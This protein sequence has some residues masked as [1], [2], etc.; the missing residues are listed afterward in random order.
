[1]KK[2]LTILKLT[3]ISIGKTCLTCQGRRSSMIRCIYTCIHK[4]ITTSLI[5][6]RV[7]WYNVKMKPRRSRCAQ[8]RKYIGLS[9]L[10]SILRSI[11]CD[12]NQIVFLNASGIQ[13]LTNLLKM[14]KVK[15]NKLIERESYK[16]E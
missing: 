5:A 11:G 3:Q 8:E 4:L 9:E 2:T 13:N 12:Y 1:M 7:Q 10:N 6:A 16:L 15:L 14:C